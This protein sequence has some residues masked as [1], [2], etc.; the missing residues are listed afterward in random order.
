MQLLITL[1]ELEA[2]ED[3]AHAP[4]VRSM[5]LVIWVIPAVHLRALAE[6]H[7]NAQNEIT[8]NGATR[9]WS[10][11]TFSPTCMRTKRLVLVA[12]A[13]T[14]LVL[15]VRYTES[16]IGGMRADLS[17][18]LAVYRVNAKENTPS[19]GRT[20]KSP[21]LMPKIHRRRTFQ[22]P[23]ITEARAHVP[24]VKFSKLPL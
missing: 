6:H 13:G 7:L 22:E 8:P 14:A 3:T 2:G 10:A 23:V 19:I 16:V 12:G 5:G 20:S 17:R 18:A 4:T 24:T 21:A 1:L 15:M 9:G 11:Q